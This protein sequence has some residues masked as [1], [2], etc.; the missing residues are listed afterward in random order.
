MEITREMYLNG[1][2]EH[3]DYYL[4]LAKECGISFERS[5]L[6]P[7]VKKLLAA[8][9]EHLNKIPLKSWD[10]LAT[11]YIDQNKL[12]SVFKAHGD[13][14][15]LAGH[16]CMLKAAAKDAAIKGKEETRLYWSESLKKHVTVPD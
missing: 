2:V 6:L 5:N 11:S 1:K 9:D 16:V 12:H 14:W 8:G 13:S 4:T 10:M 15:S 3:H 7:K